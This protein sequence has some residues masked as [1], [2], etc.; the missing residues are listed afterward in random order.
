VTPAHRLTRRALLGTATA[1]GL[2][3]AAPISALAAASPEQRDRR[4]FEFALVLEELQAAFYTE[5][6]RVGALHGEL[7]QL[8]RI[9]GGHER[10]HV[11]T[12]RALLG[13]APTS[14][15]FDFKGATETSSAF[16]RTAV[17]FEDLGVAAY[18]GQM[19]RIASKPLLATAL[20]IH[21]VEARHA[22]WIR[23]VAGVLPAPDAFDKAQS[24]RMIDS[25]VRSTRFV[26]ASSATSA[27]EFTG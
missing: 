21:A 4:I 12:I 23:R 17:A 13:H 19:S 6:E 26:V 3:G 14:P 1:A 7:A 16:V 20:S 9:V 27:P 18:K 15:R 2:S 25:I 24:E 5:A 11:R 22:A 8:A 10:A